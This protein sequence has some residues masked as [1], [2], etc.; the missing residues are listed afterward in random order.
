[1][2]FLILLFPI[3]LVLTFLA[4][5]NTVFIE[6]FYS[7]GFYLI[8]NKF[9]FFISHL[10]KFSLGEIL[11]YLF[12]L[13]A[14]F[15]IVK[16]IYKLVHKFEGRIMII[17]GFLNIL[18]LFSI[19]YFVFI[20]VWGLNYHRLPLSNII[21]LE[22]K[23][24]SIETLQSLCENLIEKT[25]TLRKNINEDEFGITYIDDSFENISQRSQLG[26]DEL[27]KKYS[28]FNLK[29][30]NPKGVIFSKALSYAGIAGVYFPFTGEAN[31]N[32]MV[33]QPM[34]PNTTAHEMAHQQGFAREDEAN[35]I[36]Y[37]A[38]IHHPDKDFQYSGMLLALIHS[39]NNLY[40]YD[41]NSYNNLRK[42]YSEGVRRDLTE[43]NNFWDKY[44]GPIERTSSKVNNAYLKSNL[45]KDGIKS[46]GRMV[47]LLIAEYRE[48]D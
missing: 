6:S 9:L 8:I 43:I 29:T 34:L 7:Q 38:C 5:K 23:P 33:P 30:S 3:S 11:L 27:G 2:Y 41:T 1:M 20:V 46:Y 24:A 12:F 31:V 48:V 45:Q 10:F 36:A 42:S 16:F 17:K 35:Y 26:Y 15:S 25:N 13:F 37:L 21:N 40:K 14:L 4:S 22:V 32:T 39:M 47:D 19:L 28:F 44:K 18:L